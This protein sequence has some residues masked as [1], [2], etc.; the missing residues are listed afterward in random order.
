MQESTQALLRQFKTLGD[1]VRARLAMLCSFG[2]CSVSELVEVTSLSQP[3]VSQHLKQ[4]C[5]AGLMERFR[6]GHFV[7][8]RVPARDDRAERRKLMALLPGDDPQFVRDFEKLKSLRATTGIAPDIDPNGVERSL[9]RALVA[10]TVAAPLGDLLDIGC[11]QGRVLKLLASR[12]GRAVGVDVD[13][14][15]RRL[16][17]AELL[18][19]ELPNCS[20][21]KGDM[22]A[23][24]F[25]DAEFDTVILDDVLATA[26][27]PAQAIAEATRLLRPG[28][29]LF[30]LSR[31][32]PENND[33]L[34]EQIA[35]LC[36]AGKLRLAPPRLIP[37]KQPRWLLAVATPV[38]LP[39]AA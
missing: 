4:L 30:F 10:L 29:R 1:P 5:D 14:D 6:D 27:Q 33:H 11:G 28:G 17:R 22:Y 15:A 13:S 32:G 34:R 7:Y 36:V 24:P 19:A 25:G 38:A 35:R 18:L 21:R 23:L 20:L 39:E 12:A 16:A 3:R 2:E 9:H 26:E 31:C 37:A 8:Y